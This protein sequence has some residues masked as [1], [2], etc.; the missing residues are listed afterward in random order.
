M[1]LV[2]NPKVLIAS[3]LV[4]LTV[5]SVGGWFF[6]PW[7]L[8][9]NKTV[10]EALPT[11]T[12]KANVEGKIAQEESVN[13]PIV[14]SESSFISHEHATSGV[15][16]ILQLENGER[17]LRIENLDTSDGPQ[18][19]IWLTDAPVIEGTDGWKVFDD[20]K[21]VS[22]GSLKGN[23]GD[24]NYEIPESLNLEEFTSMSIWCVR[25][26]VSFGAAELLLKT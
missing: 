5:V 8:F 22:L 9:T 20:G 24:Q 7:K 21:Y 13:Y 2:R 1:K 26:S 3:I 25:F 15:V 19:E 6:Q 23:L 4:A 17:I 14:L 12:K 11:A 10:I 16:K 18:L